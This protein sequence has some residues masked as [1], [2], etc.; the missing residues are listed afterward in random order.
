MK[1]A[2]SLAA[3]VFTDIVGYS[4]IVHRDE[5][6]G[7][8]LLD[9]QRA[10]VR[11]IVPEH[12]GREVETAGDSFLLEFGSALSAVQAVLAI[13]KALAADPE[14]PRVVLRASVHL[15][16]VEHRGDE[17]F[18]DGV[19]IAARLLPHSPEGGLALSEHVL[20]LIRQRLPLATRSIGSPALKNITD[21]IE[22]FIVDAPGSL[23]A[24]GQF[25]ALR[26]E[27]PRVSVCVLPFT[28]ISGDPEQDYFSDGITEDIITDLSKV[29]ALAVVSRNTSFTFKGKAAD[30]KQ[31]AQQ[32]KVS[33]VLEGSVRKQAQRVRI[34][35]QLIRTDDD[36]H[37]WAER[38]D[39]DVSD[40]FALQDEISAAIVKALKLHLMPSE[41]KKIEARSTTNAAAYKYYLMAR[42]FRATF[43]S[44]H[45]SL[46][47]RLCQRAVEIDPNYARAW[48]LM[49]VG[50]GLLDLD[51]VKGSNGMEAAQRALSIDPDLAEGLAAKARVLYTLGRFDEA[52]QAIFRAL[53]LEPD[54]YDVHATA[55]RVYIAMKRWDDAIRHLLR[56]ADIAEN[57][58]WALGMAGTCY[59]AK[60]DLAG[61]KVVARRCLERVE[62]TIA[63]QPDHGN[64]L[65]FGVG[66]LVRL[67]EKDRAME[68]ADRALLL[69]PENRNLRYNM[70]CA[71]ALARETERALELLA[72]TFREANRQGYEWF[73][74]DS[75]LD[76]LRQDPRFVRMMADLGARLAA[77]SAPA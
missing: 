64:A 26:D 66:V 61:E 11:R 12:G 19:N 71:M 47:V 38:Y 39:R 62:K 44:R 67:D 13:Q 72:V 36:S 75:D 45:Y 31:V 16:D 70:A 73:K 56:V 58:F 22:I 18:G 63:V 42:Q 21:P 76:S 51:G 53:E 6:L 9:R 27:P 24:T 5:A 50:Q 25:A 68:W 23:A 69:D 2:R 10:V 29:S 60:G 40:I 55:G 33:H 65:G 3:I 17:V 52:E 8:R 41:K 49:A 32:L 34:T 74:H 1:S 46:I 7:A 20:G 28:N 4:A 77:E 54:S 48:A 57:D 59:Q 43:N 15:G 30:I 14:Q 37:I 35:A